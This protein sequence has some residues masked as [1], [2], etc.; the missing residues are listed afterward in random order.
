[1]VWQKKVEQREDSESGQRV[2]TISSSTLDPENGKAWVHY[3]LSSHDQS[4]DRIVLVWGH[5]D[6]SDVDNAILQITAEK[7]KNLF[8]QLRQL[9]THKNKEAYIFYGLDTSRNGIKMSWA[10]PLDKDFQPIS[11]SESTLVLTY[12]ES[13]KGVSKN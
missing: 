13:Y 7:F 11:N 6:H 1:M 2:L 9:E 4:L 8:T 10:K 12:F 3:Y 5:P